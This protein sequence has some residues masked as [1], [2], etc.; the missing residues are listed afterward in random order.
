MA[1]YVDEVANELAAK[2]LEDEAR[3]GDEKIVDQISEILGT[4]SQTLQESYMTFIRVRRAE[5]RARTLLASR[6]D[7]GSAD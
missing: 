7:K 1:S 2:A 4:S 5:K 3:T 6:A